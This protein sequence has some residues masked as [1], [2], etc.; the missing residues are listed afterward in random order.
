MKK[1]EE[2]NAEQ[3]KVNRFFEMTAY[4]AMCQKYLQDG[5]SKESFAD[6]IEQAGK[7]MKKEVK[8]EQEIEPSDFN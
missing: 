8:T 2:S 7:M 6:I 3:P 5:P 1:I 4:K